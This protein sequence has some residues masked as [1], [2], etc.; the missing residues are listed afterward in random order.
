MSND[1]VKTLKMNG[2]LKALAHIGAPLVLMQLVS[3]V[4][5]SNS[6]MCMNIDMVEYFAGCMAVSRLKYS[7][8]NP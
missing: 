7:K 2:T 6:T 5:K 8:S 1:V 3:M 4:F